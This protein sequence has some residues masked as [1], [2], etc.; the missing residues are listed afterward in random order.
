MYTVCHLQHIMYCC[1]I[2]VGGTVFPLCP[3]HQGN[4]TILS[5]E[6]CVALNEIDT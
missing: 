6:S 2:T 5:E 4:A 3:S 1:G